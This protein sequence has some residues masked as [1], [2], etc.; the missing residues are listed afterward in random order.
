VTRRDH[1]HTVE[2]GTRLYARDEGPLDD[3][4]L[5]LLCLPGLTR[6]SSDF[7]PVFARYASTRRVIAMDFRGR[8]RS[9]HASDPAT[10]QPLVE[11]QD[12]ISFLDQLNIARMAVLGTSRGGIV[13]LL[14]GSLAA[15]HIEG[16]MLND[17]GCRLEP[18]G[19][20]RIRNLVSA[21]PVF[22]TWTEAAKAYA[23]NQRGFSRLSQRQWMQ[24]VKRIYFKTDAG[25]APVHDPAL[26][27]TLP[28]DVEIKAGQVAELW[29][30]LPPFNGTP[31]ALLRGAGSDLLS[32]ETVSRMQQAS[33][34]LVATTVPKRGHVPFL[35]EA[36]SV[37]AIDAWLDDV[38]AQR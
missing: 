17:V 33:P 29:T 2:D 4:R 15:T 38:D 37:A 24:V 23:K 22:K 7:D 36:E 31:F 32:A 14:M 8:G 12:T 3:A 5:P 28:S 9:S 10:Y 11:M 34:Q 18:D 35:D 13:G 16:L 30:L 25:V 27:R 19:L 20:L 26:A 21:Q 1:F 6:H